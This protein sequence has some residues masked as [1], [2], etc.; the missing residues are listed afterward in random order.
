MV[1]D[2]R[3][4]NF[5][6]EGNQTTMQNNRMNKRMEIWILYLKIVSCHWCF[7]WLD[8]KWKRVNSVIGHTAKS[9]GGKAKIAIYWGMKAKKWHL[10]NQC[11]GW[12]EP[13]KRLPFAHPDIQYSF[14]F[15]YKKVYDFL[16]WFY[17]IWNLKC[18]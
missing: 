8:T 10:W 18:N 14:W 11:F 15:F 2:E 6:T 13:K 16:S 1:D 9:I 7:I 5:Q 3:K 17:P 4:F 12:M